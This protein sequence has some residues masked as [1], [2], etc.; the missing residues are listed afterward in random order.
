MAIADAAQ[1]LA[2]EQEYVRPELENYVLSQSVLLKEI[3]KSKVKGVSDR[4]SRVPTIPSLGGKPRV[5]N[6]NGADMGVGS[7][8][9]QVPGQVTPV[10]Y[11]H[12]FSYTKQAEYATDSDE[13]AIENF[14][15][16]TRTLAPERFADFLETLLQGNASN[17][18][19]TVV[20]LQTSGGNITGLT[21]N[22]AN[23]FLD[24]EDIDVWTGVGG[25]FVTTVTVQDSDITS[26]VIW[27]L[28]PVAT[29]TI[30]IGMGLFVNGA[31]GQANTGVNGLRYFQVATNTGNWLTVQRS[32]WNGKYIAQNIAVNGALTPQIVRALHSAIQLAMGKKKA[33]ANE[34]VAHCTVNEQ[35]AWEQNALLVQHINMAELKGSES[36]DML[37][38]EASLTIAGRRFLV[39]ER[40]VPGYIDFLA[41]KNASMVETKS[42]DFYDVGG[43]TLFGLIGQ[44]G[45]QASGLVF[46]MVAEINL[47]WVQTRLNGF[48]NGI[49]I[50]HGIYGQ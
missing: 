24:D 8:P 2:S 10:C 50:E 13:K 30:T 14:A 21:V 32:A 23:L 11:I 9:T 15:T 17:Q 42:M 7:G 36:E 37:K 16:L 46:Y 12:A 31:S 4:P 41:L 40:A 6:M 29:G 45:G 33:D 27:L 44:S 19:D 35:N 22:S 5:G 49:S 38:R 43:Q 39:N 3:Q 26:N 20:G 25:A 28:N 34:L 18:L 47:I 1:A 48:L